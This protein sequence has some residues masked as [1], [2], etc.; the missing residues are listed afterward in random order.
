MLVLKGMSPYPWQQDVFAH[1]KRLLLQNKLGH[2][3]LITGE[4]GVGKAH[5]AQL[6]TR[7]LICEA[8]PICMDENNLCSSCHWFLN[9]VHPDVLTIAQDEEK[10]GAQISI[11]KIRE[12]TQFLAQTP[13]KAKK[14]I[15]IIIDAHYMN[16]Y[17]SNALLKTL[18]EPVGEGILFLLTP[19]PGSLLLTLQSRCQKLAIRIKPN[20][21]EQI[22]QFLAKSLPDMPTTKIKQ[23]LQDF[24][25]APLKAL[26]I[27]SDNERLA[28]YEKDIQLFNE[29][30]SLRAFDPFSIAKAWCEGKSSEE[31][32]QTLYLLY[33]WLIQRVYALID[34][35]SDLRQVS[36]HIKWMEKVEATRRMLQTQAGM[37]QTLQISA[38]LM[39]WQS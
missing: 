11:D 3:Y 19:T 8:A 33:M 28:A 27:L 20:R 30:L 29:F 37:N 10:R 32:S 6:L 23:C 5:F 9:S 21:E 7:Q 24:N 36:R 17:A 1:F 16:S 15:V 2:A 12:A 39:E 34:T 26:E 13:S 4:E 22:V 25:L 38:M 31:V 14:K 35:S 18:E